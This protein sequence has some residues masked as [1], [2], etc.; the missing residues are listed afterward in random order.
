MK[1]IKLFEEIEMW[2]LSNKKKNDIFKNYIEE[3]EYIL[4]D[5]NISIGYK[6]LS[7]TFCA[8]RV[9]A[10][11]LDNTKVD[12]WK[13]ET[14]DAFVEFIDRLRDKFKVKHWVSGDSIIVHIH[15]PEHRNYQGAF[16]P[17]DPW[18]A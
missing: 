17:K 10:N 1:H 6:L 11:H 12:I 15:S 5:E 7:E 14:S 16:V 18:L 2:G 8:L 3:I 13:F 9:Y 4:N